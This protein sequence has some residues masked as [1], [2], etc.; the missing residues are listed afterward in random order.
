MIKTATTA[1]R[2]KD[3]L[4][5]DRII[6]ASIALLDSKGESGL[7]FRA[8][9]EHLATGPGAIYWHIDNKNDL[10]TAACD[11]IIARTT[12][13]PMKDATPEATIRA[14]AVGLFG[15]L[16]THPWV[17]SALN[18]APGALPTIRIVERIGQQVAAMGVRP[19][20]QW[21][22]VSALLHYILGVGGQNAANTRLAL[23]QR[24]DR[25]TF[26]ND[27]STQWSQLSTADY[28]FTRGIAAS[29]STHNDLDDFVVGLDLIL[30]GITSMTR[31]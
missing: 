24:L 17:G 6:D 21:S 25:T 16:D 30:R 12:D 8:L 19:D 2:R 9:A 5:R 23:E 27:V 26:L 28:P 10:L 4:S 31:S 11:A 7:T 1:P 22:V 3:S 13:A 18:R 15:V 29:M 14:V 20:A